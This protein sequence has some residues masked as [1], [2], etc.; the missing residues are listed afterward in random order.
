MTANELLQQS[1]ISHAIYLER[2][3]TSEVKRIIALLN[4][5]DKDLVQRIASKAGETFTKARLEAL[6]RDIRSINAEAVAELRIGLRDGL[7]NLADYESKFQALRIQ[8]AIPIEWNISQPSPQT[9]HAAV[10]DRPFASALFTQH[11]THIEGRRLRLIEGAIRMGVVEGE[12]IDQIVRRV[13]GTRA[14]GYADGILEQSRRE[15]ASLVRTAVNHT[16][17]AAREE[18][19]DENSDLVKGVQYVATLDSR[20][21]LTCASLDGRIFPMHQGPRPPQH[22][23][24]RSTTTPVI[25]SWKE[26]GINLRE[27]PEG[28]R[29]SM[30]GQVAASTTFRTWLRKQPASVQRDVLGAKRYELYRDGMEIDRFVRDGRVLTLK[31]LER[32]EQPAA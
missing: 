28:T 30:N 2:L 12:S 27:A 10:F 6:L 19:Y 13:R 31:E 16:V 15:I 22:W 9:L 24:C 17:T 18:L 26:L 23:G 21:T 25:K 20:T 4:A 3:K 32:R 14:G 1:G 29:A 11:I 7:E 5:I 8:E